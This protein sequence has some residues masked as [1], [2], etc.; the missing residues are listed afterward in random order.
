MSSPYK[1]VGDIG[2]DIYEDDESSEDDDD[3]WY[4]ILI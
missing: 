1:E 2:D 4:R 3:I